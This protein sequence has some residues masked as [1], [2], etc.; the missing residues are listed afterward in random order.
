MP[1]TYN[2]NGVTYDITGLMSTMV[3]MPEKKK[4]KQILLL[5]IDAVIMSDIIWRA[6]MD[7]IANKINVDISDNA[8]WVMTYIMKVVKSAPRD[9]QKEIYNLI[10]ES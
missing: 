5:R 2:E 10:S 8:T 3:H 1:T 6:E 9:E 4:M 7:D